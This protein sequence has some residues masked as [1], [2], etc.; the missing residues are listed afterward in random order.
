MNLS[1]VS[2]LSLSDL[3]AQIERLNTLYRAGTPEVD[4]AVYDGVYLARLRELA[5]DHPLL[6]LVEPEAAGAFGAPV[7]HSAPML[8]TDKIYTQEELEAWLA[9]VEQAAIELGFP[10]PQNVSFRMT[11]KLDGLAA[12]WDG[13]VLATRGDGTFGQDVTRNIARGLVLN[14]ILEGPGEIVIEQAYFEAEIEQQFDMKAPRNF[15]VGLIGADTLKEHHKQALADGK[16]RFAS[17]QS[18]GGLTTVAEVLRAEWQKLMAAMRKECIYLTDG[19]VVEV[20]DDRIRDHMGA[21]SH[22]HRWMV[23]LKEKGE[24]ATATVQGVTLQTGRTGRVTPVIECSPVKLSGAVIRRCTAHT[25]RHVERLGLGPGA[26]FTLIRS[27]EVIPKIVSVETPSTVPVDLS[28]CPSCG[29][30]TEWDNDYLVCP[31][32]TGCDAQSVGRFEHFYLRMGLNGFGPKICEQLVAAGF[33]DPIAPLEQRPASWTSAKIPG[34]VGRNLDIA[35]DKRKSEVVR[36]ADAVASCGVRHLGRGDSR[37]LLEVFAWQ[38]IGGVSAAQIEGIPGFG[39]HTATLI[40]PHLAYVQEQLT[41]L[42]ALGFKIEATVRAADVAENPIKGKK[43]VFTGTMPLARE[44]MEQMAR[45]MGAT[46]QSGVSKT[47]D[48]LIYGDKAGS[49]LEKAQGL[50]VKAMPVAE[51]M[52]LIDTGVVQ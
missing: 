47:T 14:P 16:C 7:R 44:H 28:K 13:K 2:A 43:V 38:S 26:V 52:D 12:F 39:K 32:V 18:V 10:N 49:K 34:G 25:A 40:Q 21:T 33:R 4:D 42:A 35:I 5:P 36:D 27:G 48:L 50:G 20:T 29:G 1:A 30:A 31:N 22:H 51:Y 45:E 37:K 19:V 24:M 15:M 3:V 6:D 11:P 9:R 17:Y 23:A 8:S 46:V 41:R